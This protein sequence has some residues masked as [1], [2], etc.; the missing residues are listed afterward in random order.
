MIS[1]SLLIK[2]LKCKGQ[3][4]LI[5]TGGRRQKSQT[6]QAE[7]KHTFIPGE[8]THKVLGGAGGVQRQRETC[9]IH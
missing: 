2:E 9:K 7:M 6:S 3:G 1:F 8:E 5:S 4:I